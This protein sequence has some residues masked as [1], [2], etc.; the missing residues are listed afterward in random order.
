MKNWKMTIVNFANQGHAIGIWTYNP[1]AMDNKIQPLNICT[2][3]SKNEGGEKDYTL[4]HHTTKD[5]HYIRIK[6]I[7]ITM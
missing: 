2:I 7:N 6:L 3:T 5:P 1:Q 4:V